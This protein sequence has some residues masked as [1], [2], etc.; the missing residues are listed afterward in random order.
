MTQHAL[1]SQDERVIM[2]ALRAVKANAD[3]RDVDTFLNELDLQGFTFYSPRELNY[4]LTEE[5]NKGFDAGKDDT[6]DTSTVGGVP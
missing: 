4:M 1:D 6:E 2:H 5:W 3:L